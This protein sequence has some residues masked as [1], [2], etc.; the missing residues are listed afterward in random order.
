MLGLEG[1]VAHGLLSDVVAASRAG[2]SFEPGEHYRDIIGG[3][4][5]AFVTLHPTQILYRMGYS[6]AYYR[7]AAKPQL[8]RAVQL[9][10]PDGAGKLP[11]DPLCEVASLQPRLGEAVPEERLQAFM[12]T[13]GRFV[14]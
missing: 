11:T 9:L 13:Y 5:V 8:L 10:W 1:R 12:D 4:P 2:R 3:Y 14:N 6:M 7:R